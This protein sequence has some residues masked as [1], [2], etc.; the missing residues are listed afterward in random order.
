[1]FLI[2]KTGN[3]VLFKSPSG[4]RGIDFH[5][6]GDQSKVPETVTLFPYHMPDPAG[7]LLHFLLRI[8]S[9]T[10]K[11]RLFS[12]SIRL[13]ILPENISL[14]MI[15]SPFLLKSSLI[16]LSLSRDPCLAPECFRLLR[17]FT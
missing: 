13:S 11:N 14:Q 12:A 10:D 15:Q 16:F 2:Y 6:S 7:S 17:Q 3:L 9:L 5:I 1:M 4:S 8:Q